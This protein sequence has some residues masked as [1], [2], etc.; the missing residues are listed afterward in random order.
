MSLTDNYEFEK[1]LDQL[2]DY[3]AKS[4]THPVQ[5][6]R[7]PEDSDNK[8]MLSI[9]R[10]RG[11]IEPMRT[12]YDNGNFIDH[13]NLVYISDAGVDFAYSS[14]FVIEAKKKRREQRKW[15]FEFWKISYD[16]FISI[17]ALIISALALYI[18]MTKKG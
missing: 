8:K 12:R 13:Y 11:L 1:K 2:L 9:L 14:G 3:F 10:N 16:T 17:F 6:S 4:G 5:L 15:N 18:A 7:L